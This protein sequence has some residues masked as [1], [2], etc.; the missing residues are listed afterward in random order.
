MYKFLL[1]PALII[2]LRQVLKK[3]SDF[4]REQHSQHVQKKI[5][6]GK[7]ENSLSSGWTA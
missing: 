5:H 6:G 4:S 3:K 1:H 2:R 7:K